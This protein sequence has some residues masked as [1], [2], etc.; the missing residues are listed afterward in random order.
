ME[1]SKALDFLLG[2]G[3]TVLLGVLGYVARL[4]LKLNATVS[5][6]DQHLF[7]PEGHN[8]LNATVKQHDERLDKLEEQ[9]IRMEER[10]A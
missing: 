10:A 1:H 7:G 9:V 6:L 4:L 5:K 3:L 2:A 8:G